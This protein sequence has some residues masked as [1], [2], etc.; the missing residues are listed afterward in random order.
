MNKTI[1]VLIAAA[2]LSACAGTQR[3][4][5]IAADPK[6]VLILAP[7][8]VNPADDTVGFNVLV[9]DVTQAFAVA[10]S[11]ELTSKGYGSVNVLD[12]RPGL[13]AGEKMALY[14]VKNAAVKVATLSIETE[15]VG[16]DAQILLRAQFIEGEFTP[17]GSAPTGLRTRSTIEKSYLLRG[18][19]SGDTALSM[20]DLAKDFSS[21]LE[22]SGRIGKQGGDVGK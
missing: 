13:D 18:S 14:A 22:S 20:S 11:A 17:P 1:H 2:F 8:G 7:Q 10:F 15:T 6:K 5:S 16:G 21:F 19:R 4:T 3:P 12:Q 9:K